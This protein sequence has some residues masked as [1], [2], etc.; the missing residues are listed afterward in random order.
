MRG[1]H[2]P[3]G[4]AHGEQIDPHGRQITGSRPGDRDRPGH[5][6]RPRPGVAA[7]ARDHGHRVLAHIGAVHAAFAGVPQRVRA[8]VLED[9]LVADGIDHHR[10]SRRNIE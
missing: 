8:L 10:G 4:R 2:H 6:M 1:G 5:D 9:P 3:V 7:P